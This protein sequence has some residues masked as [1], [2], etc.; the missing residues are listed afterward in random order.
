MKNNLEKITELCNKLLESETVSIH[1]EDYNKEEVI[2]FAR[3]YDPT[4]I[5]LSDALDIIRRLEL[6][7]ELKRVLRDKD[8]SFD[9]KVMGA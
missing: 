6:F 3:K 2:N 4:V 7:Q 9:Y 1:D 8:D 5:T